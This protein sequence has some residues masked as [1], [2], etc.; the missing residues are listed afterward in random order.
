MFNP[1][2]RN[3]IA[4]LFLAVSLV[5]GGT[6]SAS[7][8]VR[9]ASVSWT[10]VTVKTELAVQVLEALGY[11]ASNTMVSVPIAYKAMEMNDA[12]VFLG[13]WMPSMANIAEKFFAKG[14]VVKHVANMPGAKYTLAAPA[15]VVEGGLQDFS[16]IARYADKLDHKIY[17][18]E[19]GNDGNEVIQAMIDQDMFGLGDFELIPSS[20]AGMLAQV[21]AFARRDKWIVFLGWAPHHMNEIIDMKYL[22]GSTEDTFGENNG[23]ATVYTNIRRGFAEENPNVAT[24]LT[25]FTFPIPMMNAIMAMLNENGGLEPAEAGLIWVRKNPEIYRGWLE[26][27]ETVDGRPALPAFERY[28]KTAG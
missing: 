25:N 27:V 5:A 2:P 21:Q 13:N 12:D 16:D 14:T 24:F 10:G 22:T 18:I 4:I 1:H 20:E 11:E 3:F 9:F 26:G 17:G 6:A 28:L 15:Y 19:E 7:E 8:E 23:T